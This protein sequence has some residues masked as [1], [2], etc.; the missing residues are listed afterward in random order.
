VSPP[1][2]RSPSPFAAAS[3]RPSKSSTSTRPHRRGQRAAQRVRPRRRGSGPLGGGRGGRGGRA[4]DD[5]GPLAGVPFGVKDLENCEG[6]PTTFG[7]LP[8]AGRGPVSHDDLNV[9]RLRA[10]VRSRSARRPARVRHVELHQDQG[11]RRHSQSLGH[12]PHPGG[13]SGGTSAAS[14]PGSSRSAPPPT[15]VDRFAFPRRHRTRR[16]QVQSRRIPLRDRRA[17]RLGARSLTTTVADTARI[18]TYSPVP[19]PGPRVVATA[20]VRYEDAI[21]HTEVRGLR[22]RWSL[23][24]GFALVDPEVA[25]LTEA[26][27]RSLADAAGLELDDEPVVLRTV[28]T[29]LTTGAIGLWLDIEPDM[30]P[31]RADDFTLYVRQSL[32]QTEGTTLPKYVGRSRRVS[33]SST[34]VRASSTRSTSCCARPPQCRFAAEGP[35]RRHRWRRDEAAGDVDAVSRCSQTSVGTRRRQCPQD[36]V[37]RVCRSACRSSAAVISTRCHCGRR[38]FEQANPWPASPRP[39]KKVGY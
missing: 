28:R 20:L 26:A 24:L 13:S 32:E 23:D 8:F 35:R 31:S 6:M 3:A 12:Q 15:V 30:W 1:S 10:R 14:L 37:G 27:A 11:L 25:E 34:T 2:S 17:T 39:R 33:N 18:S 7:S 5:P 9:A 16:A 22:A 36:D 21:E 29:W 38:I 19:R 4:S